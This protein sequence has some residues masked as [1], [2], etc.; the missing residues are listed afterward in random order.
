MYFNSGYL[1]NSRL[2]FKDYTKPLVVGSCGT[3]RLKKRPMLPTYWKKGRRD[4][5]ILYVASGK[6]HFW[7]NG[8]EEIVDSGHMVL[9]KPKEVQKY[10][11]YVEDHPEVF[12]IHFTGY[13]VKNILE[14]HGISL[15]QHVF[16]SGTL[17]EY[18]MSFRKIIR[19]LQQCEY[20]YEDYIASS[21][22]NIL[23]L[24]SRQQQNGENYTVTIP[25]EIEI[26]VSY[27]NENYNTKISVAQYA[28]SL[29]IST[30]W[31]IRNFKQHM[32][33]SPAQYL[34]SLR[35]V[36]A[37]SLLENTD[38]SVGEI[39]E[40]VGYD[41]QLYFS[42]VFKKEYGISQRSIGKE[43]KTKVRHRWNLMSEKSLVKIETGVLR[44]AVPAS[45]VFIYTKTLFALQN[46][47]WKVPQTPLFCIFQ[48]RL[49]IPAGRFLPGDAL[50]VVEDLHEV[51]R[52]FCQRSMLHLFRDR[53]IQKRNVVQPGESAG[54]IQQGD[55]LGTSAHIAVHPV[56]PNIIVGAGGGIRALGVDHQ[57]VR[58]GILVQPGCR[59][60]IVRPAFPVPGQAVGRALGKGK[61]F[62]GFAWHSVPPFVF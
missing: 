47:C 8:I 31:F 3:Y 26:A 45:N 44:Y 18:K 23:L 60:Q 29:H 57:L 10:V 39:A 48:C 34:L 56:V 43:Q 6:A 19:E 14:Y 61:I 22:N 4:Y 27:F 5:Q 25:E 16:Y 40:I 33:M 62:F 24:V 12:W 21:F 51:G 53:R 20:G 9:Y 46:A 17:P 2:D 52:G 35:M 1:N 49:R 36:N 50:W 15:N 38:Y 28:E 58:K 11:Y 30:N 13:D 32:K 41:N 55:A 7:F 54:F 42:R 37:Q 59:G